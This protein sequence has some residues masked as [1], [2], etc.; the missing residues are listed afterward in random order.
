MITLA[1]V[2]W[3]PDRGLRAMARASGLKRL[4]PTASPE[5]MPRAAD[6]G[7]GP[8][9][10]HPETTAVASIVSSVARAAEVARWGIG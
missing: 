3:E 7:A 6:L 9:A 2:S 5:L 8:D 1:T 10:E 4:R